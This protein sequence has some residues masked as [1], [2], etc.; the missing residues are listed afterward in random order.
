M[1]RIALVILALLSVQLH[2]SGF[3][4]NEQSLRSIA[5]SSAYVAAAYG[6][7]SSYFN[8]ANMG[9]L[10]GIRKDKH[11]LEVSLTAIY[12]PGFNFTTDTRTKQIGE[13]SINWGLTSSTYMGYLQNDGSMKPPIDDNLAAVAKFFGINGLDTLKNPIVVQ[14]AVPNQHG[15]FGY[16]AN[17]AMVDGSADTT[18]FPVPKL[19]YKSESFL[20]YGGGGF[21]AGLAFTA[22]S[23]LAMTWNGE[24]GDFLKDVM[25]AILELS[26]AIS[27][28]FRE[29]ISIG[30]SPRILYGMGNFNNTV[31]VPLQGDVLLKLQDFESIPDALIPPVMKEL[32][33]NINNAQ[34]MGGFAGFFVGGGA[35]WNNRE[36]YNNPT[37]FS[38]ERWFGIPAPEYMGDYKNISSYN[39][40]V[41]EANAI[42]KAN[43]NHYQN[44]WANGHLEWRYNDKTCASQDSI[45]L[46]TVFNPVP[47]QTYK[48]T[49]PNGIETTGFKF[50]NGINYC[51]K[52]GY[53][54]SWFFGCQNMNYGELNKIKAKHGHTG[55]L[56]VNCYTGTFYNFDGT[57]QT[58][59]PGPCNYPNPTEKDENGAPRGYNYLWGAKEVANA[60]GMGDMDIKTILQ[61]STKVE[62]RS[63][64][65]DLAFGYRAGITYR[66]INT[67]NYALT[68]S[69]V[70]DS[71]V[72]FKFKGKLDADTYIGDPI[73]DVNMKADLALE[74][75]LPAQLKVGIAQ[76]IYNLT[77]EF[78]YEKIWWSGGKKFDFSFSNPTFTA[79]NPDSLVAQLIKAGKIDS[80][81]DMANYNAVAMGNGWKDTNAYRL[82]F[83]YRMDNG[84]TMMWSVAYDESPVP[85]EQIGIPDSTAYIVG[86][87]IN[88]PVTENL[89]LGASATMYLKDGSKSIYQSGD[90]GRLILANLSMGYS[91]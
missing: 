18:I 71:P 28:Q 90:L 83:T 4:I 70:F 26:P 2:A 1:F 66:P 59:N 40:K 55:D 57:L 82:G 3:K 62:Q 19:F 32:I 16:S 11:D 8:P 25:I 43:W 80:M 29:M 51:I 58:T 81:M 64:G 49:L 33:D 30:F 17:G 50:V 31:Y 6:A 69:V 44:E 74:T 20:N 46:P 88:F 63:N 67:K 86:G 14:H 7:D 89:T 42:M 22:P 76:R 12:I 34:N 54:T 47:N 60:F 23:G 61:G 77:I 41:R 75:Q 73:G 78:V 53:T 15:T 91:F 13:G 5:L 87:G 38:P 45:C 56:Y 48:T 10:D 27:Y 36:R 24:A 35:H 37:L 85:Q 39:K 84:I 52:N 72:K 9:F 68:A 65:A 79:L 21:N